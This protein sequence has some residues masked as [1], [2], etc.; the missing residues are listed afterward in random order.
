MRDIF[1]GIGFLFWGMLKITW[2]LAVLAGK[3]LLAWRRRA[4]A[5]APRPASI[6]VNAPSAEAADASGPETI[7][8]SSEYEAADRIASIRLDPPVG[9][10]NLR[11]YN[12]SKVIKRDLIIHEPRL[13]AMM[14]GRRHSFADATFDPVAGLDTVKDESIDLAEKLINTLGNQSVRP[15]KPTKV[16]LPKA[17]FAVTKEVAAAIAAPEPAQLAPAPHPEATKEPQGQVFSPRAMK[18]LTYVGRLVSA[19]TEMMQPKGRIPYEIFQATLL[20]DNGQELPLRGAE[21]ER[22]LTSN[23]CHVGSRVAITPMGKVPVELAN[24]VEGSKNLYRVKNMTAAG[25]G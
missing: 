14:R 8:H 15:A 18:G 9:V 6:A 4:A 5:A 21:L 12:A 7:I 17:K 22:E 10:I 24:G 16:E 2:K 19:G 11:V 13:K 1:M 3:A 23:G 20:L 25:K